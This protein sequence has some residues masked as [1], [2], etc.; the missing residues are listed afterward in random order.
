[1][2]KFDLKDRLDSQIYRIYNFLSEIHF[3]FNPKIKNIIAENLALKNAHA[4]ERCF[5]LGTG[6][7]LA[8]LTQEQIGAL[9]SEKTFALNSFYKS[10]IG[11]QI[12]PSFY[13]AIDNNYWELESYKKDIKNI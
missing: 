2:N 1:M 8:Q 13:A 4:G 3:F 12:A 5:I 11:K 9:A 7:S 6:P 10:A